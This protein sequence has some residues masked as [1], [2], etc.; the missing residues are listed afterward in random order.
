MSKAA[1]TGREDGRSTDIIALAIAAVG[2]A[3]AYGGVIAKLVHDWSVNENYSHGF[4]I[5]PLSI[6]LAW[7]RRTRLAAV[8]VKPS[9]TGLVVLAGG[10]ATLAAGTIGAELFVARV[11]LL[12]VLSGTVLFIWG[13]QHLRIVAFPVAFLLLMIPLP[14]I[15][16]NQIAF[17]LQLL[18][19]QVGELSL[20]S[21]DIPVLRQG[22]LITLANTTLEVAEAC[23]GIRSL[24]SLLT[25]SIVY[26]YFT[27]RDM[28]RRL[29]L[30]FATIPIAILTN[31]LRVAALGVVAYVY[32][33]QAVEGFFHTSSGWG[34]FA[35][36][37]AALISVQRLLAVV[38]RLVQRAPRVELAQENGTC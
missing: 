27:E 30:I 16:F 7:E 26:A 9:N 15:I 22:N 13:W 6:Y 21:M 37:F 8:P 14:M 20:R 32:G 24:V 33:Q 38:A 2:M 29:V 12:V 25:L 36:A 18:A 4:L 17:P 31:G 11:S 35:L 10:L 3:I 1:D 28:W 19:S 23:S 34:I 5:V